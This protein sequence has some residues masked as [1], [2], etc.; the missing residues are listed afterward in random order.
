MVRTLLLPCFALTL[1]GQAPL[2]IQSVERRGLPPYEESATR[3][4]RLDGGE[5]RGLRSGD[6]L[7]VRRPGE[8]PLAHLRVV[9]V[10]AEW[11]MATLDQTLATYPLRG[12]LVMREEL[13]ALPPF[14][15]FGDATVLPPPRPALGSSAEAPPQEGLLWFLPGSRE[16]S[17]AGEAKLAAWVDAWG[18][19]GR[20]SILLPEDDRVA[21]ALKHAR[22][23][24][25]RE[26]LARRGVFSVARK[27][28]ARKADGPNHPLWI[29]HRD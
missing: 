21:E 19:E 3:L 4:Y 25:L 10:R 8:G 5:N 15:S 7:L 24:A 23:E 1:L 11:A 20:W 16:L 6:R 9:E 26:A 2:R 17:P 22:F 12:D 18:R 27:D 14:P 13:P 29:Q 28:E